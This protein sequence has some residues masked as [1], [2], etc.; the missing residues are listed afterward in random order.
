MKFDETT[1]IF[2]FIKPRMPAVNK[3]VIK[4]LSKG[5]N[6]NQKFPKNK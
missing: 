5:K 1:L 3:V 2:Q 6:T 4:A